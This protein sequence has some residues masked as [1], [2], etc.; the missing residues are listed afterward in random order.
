MGIPDWPGDGFIWEE[1]FIRSVCESFIKIWHQEQCQGST[2]P[3]NLFLEF[4]RTWTFLI[5]LEVVLYGIEHLSEA[6]VKVLSRIDIWDH[7]I[8]PPILNISSWSFGGHGH[9]WWTWRWCQMGGNIHKK[10]LWRFHQ[11]P[12]CFGCI[13]TD[14][15]WGLGW[16]RVWFG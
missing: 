5:D 7:L 15:E 9:S 12:T 14:L 8:N 13:R 11:D 6:S 1:T 2:C 4:R 16:G 3:P 10:L